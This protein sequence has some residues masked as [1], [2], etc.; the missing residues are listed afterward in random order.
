M[1]HLISNTHTH[2]HLLQ[3][4]IWQNTYTYKCTHK[5]HLK[6]HQELIITLFVAAVIFKQ[7]CGLATICREH[8]VSTIYGSNIYPVQ[9]V[10]GQQLNT[11]RET[12]K[13][14]TI[15]R[16]ERL[17]ISVECVHTLISLYD[18]F[19]DNFPMCNMYCFLMAAGT[20]QMCTCTCM[21]T[22]TTD[23]LYITFFFQ[24]D[25]GDIE[26][27]QLVF[28][29]YLVEM[30]AIAASGQDAVGMEMKNMAEHLKSYPQT[31]T[32]KYLPSPSLPL[33]LHLVPNP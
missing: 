10:N 22:I 1:L 5:F 2:T 15:K 12:E 29:N 32:H 9:S 21:T 27:A 6:Y 18:N 17:L 28:Q 16:E 33:S 14:T 11:E 30:S 4:L 19:V 20:K 25:Q 13:Q 7:D 8:T 31:H 3:Q 26:T 24:S 23:L